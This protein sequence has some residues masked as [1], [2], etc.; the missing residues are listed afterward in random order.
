MKMSA[1]PPLFNL[2]SRHNFERVDESEDTNFYT[3]PRL[4]VHVDDHFIATLSQ[5][6][7]DHL[8]P[9]ATI[10]DLMSSY[11]SHLPVD[12]KAAKIIG[13][14]MNEAE[15]KANDQLDEY[16][17]QNLNKNPV[18]P[19]PDATFDAVLTTVSVQYLIRP[20]EVFKEV[21]RVLKPGGQYIV[22]FSNRMFPTKAVRIWREASEELR[23]A[24]VEQYFAENGLFNAP[25]VFENIDKRH[26]SSNVFSVFFGANDPVY[27][28]S[29]RRK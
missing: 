28:V 3:M 22:S 8:P 17:L 6:Y 20:V 19:Y 1:Q 11:K 4:V 26:H 16:F 27:I 18:L 21:G 5:F 25:E 12:Y 13:H 7:R 9:N 10:L 24:L 29:A 14:G 23:V 2:N 15:L